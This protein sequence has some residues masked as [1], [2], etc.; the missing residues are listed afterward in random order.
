MA[1]IRLVFDRFDIKRRSRGEYESRLDFAV[2]NGN[3]RRVV[4]L[5]GGLSVRQEFL[6][7]L[8]FLVDVVEDI[9]RGYFG[10]A[11][12]LPNLSK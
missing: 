10:D 4:S 6:G 11:P 12:N 9:G 1:D 2:T 8:H 5:D 7:N 3:A